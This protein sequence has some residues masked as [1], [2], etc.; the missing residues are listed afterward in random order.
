MRDIA[1]SIKYQTLIQNKLES[2]IILTMNVDGI[3]PNKGSDQNIWP[4]LLAK[5]KI[6]LK[7]RYSPENVIIAG[8]WFGL[9]KPSRIQMSL[10]FKYIVFELQELEKI[11]F[12]NCTRLIKI[13][14]LR[15]LKSF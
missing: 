8:I 7:K 9:S 11:I 12:L 14:I 5:N 4:A 13:I 3:Q 1:D 2:F 10:L 6:N 15:L